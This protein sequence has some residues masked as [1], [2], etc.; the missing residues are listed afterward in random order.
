MQKEIIVVSESAKEE[1]KRVMQQKNKSGFGVR[2]GIVSSSCSTYTYNI[3]FERTPA[4]SD[5]VIEKNGLK[6]FVSRKSLRLLRGS[7]IDFVPEKNGF[8]FDNPNIKK[9]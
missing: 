5:I 9:T 6:F 7:R 2:V 1:L 3:D 4:A 8:V